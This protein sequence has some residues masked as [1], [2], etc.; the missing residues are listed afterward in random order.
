MEKRK[1]RIGVLAIQG[2]VQEHIESVQRAGGDTVEI[3]LPQQ[4]SDIDG[5]I[6]PGGESTAMAIVGEKWGLFPALKEWVSSGRPIWGTCAG[7]ILLSD[8]AIKQR[9]G[10]QALVG[11]LDVHVCRNYFGAQIH[12]TSMSLQLP[13]DMSETVRERQGEGSDVQPSSDG[14]NSCNAVFIR[15]PAILKT[16]PSVQVLASIRAAPCEAAREEVLRLLRPHD[17]DCAGDAGAPSDVSFAEQ[18]DKDV[19]EDDVQVDVDDAEEGSRKRRRT[20][21]SE[22]FQVVVAARQGNILATAFHP[23][24]TDDLRWHKYFLAMASVSSA[25]VSGIQDGQGSS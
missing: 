9:T 13:I 14:R 22:E 2:A 7:M 3:K 20:Q 11:G 19:N 15:A 5:I 10:G 25:A 8:H 6:L 24:L 1:V 4:I 23:E 21:G 12:S 16:G 17:N 18:Q